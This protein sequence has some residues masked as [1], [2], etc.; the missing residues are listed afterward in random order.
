MN[1]HPNGAVQGVCSSA[2]GLATLL[3]AFTGI[4]GYTGKNSSGRSWIES[5]LYYLIPTAVAFTL[6]VLAPIFA[7]SRQDKNEQPLAV[8][9][10][11]LSTGTAI[12]IIALLIFFWQDVSF[13]ISAPK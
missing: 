7:T 13:G 1:N 10:A 5:D 9:R 8:A 6:L 2:I 12:G 4:I 11:L 3:L